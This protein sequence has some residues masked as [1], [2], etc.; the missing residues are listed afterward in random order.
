MRMDKLNRS[1]N[2]QA[3]E[4]LQKQ[5]ISFI[6]PHPGER[7]RWKALS[8]SAIEKMLR[9]GVIEAEIAEQVNLH[10]RT[11]HSAQ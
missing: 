2:Q 11:F 7:E 9:D 10:L 5:G 6:L 8:E 1:D 3:I 4:A